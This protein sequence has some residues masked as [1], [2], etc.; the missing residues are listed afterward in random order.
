MRYG[1]FTPLATTGAFA[2]LLAAPALYAQEVLEVTGRD[3][4]IE[5]DFEEIH[6]VGAITGESWEMF[7]SVKKVGFD[8]AGN[9]YVFDR[10]GGG[11]SGD[12]R[13]VVFDAAGGFVREFGSA[14]EGPGEF[15][16][17][18][19]IA[20]MRD[21]TAV[22]EDNGH[23]AYQIFDPAGTFMRMVRMAETGSK[24]VVV[25]DVFPDPRGGALYKPRDGG[26]AGDGAAPGSR[27]VTRIG[28][29]GEAVDTDTVAVGWQPSRG[30]EAI[31]GEI[32]FLGGKVSLND[33]LGN[34]AVPS[35]FEPGLLLGVLPD[36]GLV[37]SDSSAYALKITPPDTPEVIRIISRPFRPEPVTESIRKEYGEKRAG[38]RRATG[39]ASGTTAEG[40][41]VPIGLSFRMP[42]P[43]FFPEIPVLRGLSTTWEGRIWVQRRGEEP[44]S[45]GP[46]DVLTVAG[47]YLGTLRS[48]AAKMPD[49]FGP[50]G[51]AAFIEL[52]EFDVA[53]VVVRRLPET[54]R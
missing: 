24:V 51:M 25:T 12:A 45:D 6:R 48:D 35:E 32:N 2:L 16:D 15:R 38:R 9:L 46:I 52:D 8:A 3:S 14:G 1:P 36:G 43:T 20:I 5:A 13:I 7:A 31:E 50:N 27:P 29:A 40:A 33:L 47:D 53:S 22:V 54:I 28:L 44:E 23:D 17:P 26:G 39:T 11:N 30:G 10:I 49:A 19:N 34:F 42:E 18:D 37:Y 41:S 4:H 21:G